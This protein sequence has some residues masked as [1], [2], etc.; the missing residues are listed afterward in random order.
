MDEDVDAAG[1]ACARRPLSVER[2]RLAEEQALLALRAARAASRGE[3]RRCSSWRRMQIWR[4]A[5]GFGG[6]TT[7]P[8]RCEVPCS[9]SRICSGLP[10]V[11]LQPDALDV[12]AGVNARGARARSSGARRGRC[13]ASAWTSSMTTIRRSPKSACA[14]HPRRDQHHLERLRR[15]HQELGRLPHERALFAVG[16]RR[17]ARRSAG[18]RPSRRRAP[19]RSSWLFSSALIGAR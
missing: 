18:G 11:A 8:S 17:R 19:S 3:A 2:A 16:R 7:T 9:Q 12:V 5:G 10:T 4:F 14:G 1:R 15:R 13:P 6:S